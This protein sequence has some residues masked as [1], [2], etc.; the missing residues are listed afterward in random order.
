M[1]HGSALDAQTK[2]LG[3]SHPEVARILV[4]RAETHAAMGNF[5]EADKDLDR[6]A[7][8]LEGAL[9]PNDA[10]VVSTKRYLEQVRRG[11]QPGP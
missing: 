9:G 6:A 10:E 5:Q 3:P 1:F 8:I 11:E 7:A 4:T 2:A